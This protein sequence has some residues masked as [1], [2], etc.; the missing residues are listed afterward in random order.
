MQVD[1]YPFEEDE[2]VEDQD[3]WYEDPTAMQNLTNEADF[4]CTEYP[5]QQFEGQAEHNQEPM[6]A[7][8]QYNFS[9]PETSGNTTSSNIEACSVNK[10]INTWH[11]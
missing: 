11:Q 3:D 1:D 7:E 5:M 10:E 8:G 2:E 9:I 6:F 4:D